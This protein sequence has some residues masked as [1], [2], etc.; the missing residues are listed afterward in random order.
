VQKLLRPSAVMLALFLGL[1]PMVAGASPPTQAQ[2][3]GVVLFSGH[4]QTLVRT[5]DG[6]STFTAVDE[7]TY[8]G[9][10]SGN[11]VAT[12]RDR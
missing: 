4:T 5:A 1:S 8:T 9:G 2:A 11:V 6:N 12:G 10:I 7:V 3:T